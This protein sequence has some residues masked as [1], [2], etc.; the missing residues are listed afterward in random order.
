MKIFYLALAIVLTTLIL[1]L[2]FGNIGAQCS[3]LHFLFFPV[4]SN[5]TIIIMGI[6]VL[7]ILTGATYHAFV[8][9]VLSDTEEEEDVDF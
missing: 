9:R 1:I 8:A 3:A 2:S 5:P 7:G 4:Q 6:A